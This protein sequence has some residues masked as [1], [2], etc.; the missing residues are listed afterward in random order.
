MGEGVEWIFSEAIIDT[1]EGHGKWSSSYKI[2]SV[3]AFFCEWK[4]QEGKTKR[5]QNLG[6]G[7]H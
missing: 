3:V 5:S 6:H 7:K 1:M 4:N 2:N